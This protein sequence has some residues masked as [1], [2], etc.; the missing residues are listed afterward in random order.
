MNMIFRAESPLWD[1]RI[2]LLMGIKQDTGG[3]AV[4]EPL[5]FRT[6]DPGERINDPTLRLERSDAQQLVDALWEAGVRPT[7]GKGSAGQLDAVQAH[8]KDLQRLVFERQPAPIVLQKE[9]PF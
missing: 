8:L 7:A 6:L 2:H 3:T 5:V 9:S 4:V 1:D